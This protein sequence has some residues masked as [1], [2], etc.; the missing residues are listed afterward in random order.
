MIRRA[1]P[2]DAVALAQLQVRTLWATYGPYVEHDKIAAVL[3]R[4]EP[5][6]RERLAPRADGLEVWVSEQD[7]VIDGW[8][9]VGPSR[10]PDARPGDGELHAIYVEPERIGTGLG[11]ALLA[12]AEERLD[13]TDHPAAT[14]WTLTPN[15]QARAFY[16][17]H[18]WTE[19][20]RPGDNPYADW[21]P[22]VRYR[23][24]LS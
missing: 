15:T 17:R 24:V 2:G 14:L 22:S 9:T 11:R 3:P 10:D 19:D 21:S 4:L 20:E 16:E 5:G 6:W 12:R 18:G 7:G 1:A 13:A 23:K 8:V